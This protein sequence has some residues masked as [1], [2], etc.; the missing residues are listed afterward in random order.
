MIII[1][2]GGILE[3]DFLIWGE[4]PKTV[5]A[6]TALRPGRKRKSGPAAPDPQP[7]CYDAETE[8]RALPKRLG[9][10]P[11]WRGEARFLDAMETIYRDASPIGLKIFLGEPLS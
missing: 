9:N 8:K 6:R 2:H 1:L 3:G 5:D 11:F 7:L 10:F 4:T